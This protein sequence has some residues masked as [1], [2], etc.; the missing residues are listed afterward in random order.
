MNK[1][2]RFEYEKNKIT[3]LKCP[4]CNIGHL[5]IKKDLLNTEQYK[6]NNKYMEEK[7]DGQYFCIHDY[8]GVISGLLQ[9]SHCNDYVSFTGEITGDEE[10]LT[11][12]T[13]QYYSVN[14]S[15]LNFKYI[16]PPIQIIPI[17]NE[18]P[19]IIKEI[20]NE[21]FSFYF[22]H[23][24]SCINKLRVLVEEVL[25]NLDIQKKIKI[26]NGR[27]AG[28]FRKLSTHGRL[29]VLETKNKYKEAS[30]YLLAL[31]WIGNKGSHKNSDFTIKELLETYEILEKALDLIYV[32][33]ET[34]LKRI[35]TQINKQKGR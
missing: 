20:L 7:Y 30:E 27:N 34:K 9:C 22:N 1:S 16:N 29:E 31:K 25:N 10:H 24:A 35:I 23:S 28:K 5:V 11:D 32:K 8:L 33:S 21:S 15:Y 19:E 26:R 13:G 18:Y 4:H 12:E 6:H 14:I 2:I 3:T 17:H